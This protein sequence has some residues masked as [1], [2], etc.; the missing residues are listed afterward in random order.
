MTEYNNPSPVW[1]GAPG[2]RTRTALR[3]LLLA[4][5]PLPCLEDRSLLQAAHQGVRPPPPPAPCSCCSCRQRRSPW[6]GSASAHPPNIPPH[7]RHAPSSAPECTGHQAEL[8]AGTRRRF[9]RVSLPPRK[10]WS[11]S[12]SQSPSV[13]YSLSAQVFAKGSPSWGTW[14]SQQLRDVT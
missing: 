6:R 13:T 9:A 10:A 1:A 12:D 7:A 14:L 5:P 4:L 2:W 3:W 8:G 11:L